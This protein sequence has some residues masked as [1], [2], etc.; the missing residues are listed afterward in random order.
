VGATLRIFD[1]GG[2]AGDVTHA[3]PAGA[4]QWRGLGNP[5]GSRGFLYRGAGTPADPCRIVLVKKGIVRAVCTGSGVTLAP[6]FAGEVR[7]VLRIGT[8]DRYCASFGG[9]ETRNDET[10][11]R[12]LRAGPPVACP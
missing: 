4:T 2:A 1:T 12:R 9:D 7:V 3:L 11:T 6:P 10:V 8:T 5:A